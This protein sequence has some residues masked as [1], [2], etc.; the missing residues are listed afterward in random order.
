MK[1]DAVD[2]EPLGQPERRVHDTALVKEVG[3]ELKSNLVIECN[4]SCYVAYLY[5]WLWTVSSLAFLTLIHWIANYAK[6]IGIGIGRNDK[7]FQS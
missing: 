3:A 5:K 7:R 2:L 1:D 4:Q 6:R